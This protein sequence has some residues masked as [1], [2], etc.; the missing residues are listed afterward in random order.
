MAYLEYLVAG[1]PNDHGVGHEWRRH[2]FFA[3]TVSIGWGA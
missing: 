3:F 2:V 1:S